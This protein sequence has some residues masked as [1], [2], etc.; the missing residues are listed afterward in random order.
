MKI[1]PLLLLLWA[2][3]WAYSQVD[4]LTVRHDPVFTKVLQK[5]IHYPRQ[6]ESTAMQAKIYAGF[7]INSEGHI[8]DI[9]ILNPQK[10]G[11]GFE[12]AVLNGLKRLPPL[13]HKY[14]GSYALPIAFMFENE[15]D[16]GSLRS[17]FYTDRRLL[18]E[19]K[20]VGNARAA[21][22]EVPLIVPRKPGYPTF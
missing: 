4:S 19:F 6:A 20:V 5:R 12:E 15:T 17:S 11:L 1:G 2:Q 8:Q 13:S 14:A 9:S 18:S 7:T 16:L 3:T 21:Q 22:K 10:I